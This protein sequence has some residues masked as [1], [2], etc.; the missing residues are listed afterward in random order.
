M[1]TQLVYISFDAFVSDPNTF[2]RKSRVN[3]FDVLNMRDT[4]TRLSN[5]SDDVVNSSTFPDNA[6]LVDRNDATN[7]VLNITRVIDALSTV[8]DA[9]QH[10]I[11]RNDARDMM[12][13]FI[14]SH[15]PSIYAYTHDTSNRYS[16]PRHLDSLCVLADL[17]TSLRF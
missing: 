3:L 12:T 8:I 10:I 17:C 6:L 9:N 13:T 1:S 2:I 4:L 16:H 15:A 11:D 14:H 7:N 5:I